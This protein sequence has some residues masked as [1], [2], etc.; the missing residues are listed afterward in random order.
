MLGFAQVL[1]LGLVNITIFLLISGR[2]WLLLSS[3]G[4]PLPFLTLTAYRLL[5][6]GITYFTPGPQFGGETAQIYLLNNRNRVP[7]P[8]AIASVTMD[9]ILDMLTNFLF[10]LFGVTAALKTGIF[11]ELAPTETIPLILLMFSLLLGYAF[12]L[13]VGKTPVSNFINRLPMRFKTLRSVQQAVASTEHEIYVFC[14]QKPATI[15]RASGLS[16]IILFGSIFEYYLTLHFLGIRLNITQTIIAMMA[17]RIAFLLP[18][19]GGVGFLEASQVLAMHAMGLSPNSG[20]G[21]ILMMRGRDILMGGTG[22]LLGAAIARRSL[23][24]L[25]VEPDEADL[26]EGH[27]EGSDQ[28][29]E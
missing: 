19:P 20:I 26:T 25:P 10:M 28:P 5:S 12:A 11:A 2:W 24:K 18:L 7:P 15:A 16:L 21:I 22:L 1:T 4:F 9:K 29:D 6:F 27:E 13:W 3:L 23:D 8:S 17:S 14:H